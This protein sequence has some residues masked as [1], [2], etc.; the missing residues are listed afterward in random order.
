MKFSII[1][2]AFWTL[3]WPSFGQTPD[4]DNY[5]PFEKGLQQYELKN[6]AKALEF[7]LT[8]A[9]E[10]DDYSAAYYAGEI[11]RNGLVLSCRIMPS[12]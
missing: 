6:Y 4:P 3:S 5:M 8:D 2:L 12:R 1:I 11:Y 10:N 9:K 7:F